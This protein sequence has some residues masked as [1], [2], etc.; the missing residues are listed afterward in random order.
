MGLSRFGEI[1]RTTVSCRSSSTAAKKWICTVWTSWS[2]NS[3]KMFFL[4]SLWKVIK[5][6]PVTRFQL[7]KEKTSTHVCS[8]MLIIYPIAPITYSTTLRRMTI[9]KSSTG[10][11]SA[12]ILILKQ[13]KENV[14]EL[15]KAWV[16][17]SLIF[18]S[19]LKRS[20]TNAL[21]KTAT[22]R[23]VKWATCTNTWKPMPA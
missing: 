11:L 3:A 16:S 4:P 23:S 6:K 17:F 22:Q 13:E 20:L 12:I 19:I 5:S 15:Y 10:C 1:N 7:S 21:I 18:G 9:S 2:L 8:D 14:I